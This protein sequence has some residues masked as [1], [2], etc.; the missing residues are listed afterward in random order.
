MTPVLEGKD[1]GD[2]ANEDGPVIRSPPV[3]LGE[4]DHAEL[5]AHFRAILA[6]SSPD[7]LLDK[8]HLAISSIEGQSAT[9]GAVSFARKAKSLVERWLAKLVDPIPTEN[10]TLDDNAILIERDTILLV[11]VKVGSGA[12]ASDLACHFRVV[13]VY[14]K[15]YNKWFMSKL[16][17]KRWKK[18]PKPYNVSIR[19]L[20]KN[21]LNEYSDVDLFGVSIF[22]KK[23]IFQLVEDRKI[24]NV[25]GKLNQV[26]V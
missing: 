25:V 22:P 24:L 16:G 1:L 12:S 4:N 21:A 8:V 13:T 20:E 11:H 26:V 2:A 5:M 23:D 3:T 17:F 14:E 18:E 6:V 7:D 15:Y 9:S 19:M 10:N